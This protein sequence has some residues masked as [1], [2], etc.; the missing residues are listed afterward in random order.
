MKFTKKWADRTNFNYA[1]L[2][3]GEAVEGVLR[4]T[5]VDHYTHWV[6]GKT[7][8]CSGRATCE[9]CEQKIKASYRFKTNIIVKENGV[10]TAK[11]LEQGKTVY[12][13]IQ[14]LEEGGYNLDT[15][16]IRI[17]RKGSK[18][19]TVYTVMPVPN[20]VMSEETLKAIAAVKLNDLT[21]KAETATETT[22]DDEALP[23]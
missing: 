20:A 8:V 17:S 18:L 13:A 15:T 14:A 22:H 7:H 10:L 6:D 23:F 1:S 5:L 3:D 12:E 16:K 9:L 21:T 11:I 4:G 19:D 2:K